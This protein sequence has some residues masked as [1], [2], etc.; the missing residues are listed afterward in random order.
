MSEP[1]VTNLLCPF[2]PAQHP[3]IEEVEKDSVARWGARMGLKP[4]DRDFVKMTRARFAS[5]AG[6]AHPGATLERLDP[7]VDFIIF[8][9]LWDDQFDCRIG[10]E[11]VHPAALYIQ[12]ALATQVLEGTT[13]NEDSSPLL[14]ALSDMRGWLDKH[15]PGI[16]MER[17]KKSFVEYFDSTGWEL[18][19][20]HECAVP[21]LAKYVEMRRMTSGGYWVTHLIEVAE[22]I[23]LSDEAW[24]H[25]AMQELVNATANIIG[26]ANDLLSLRNELNDSGH[27]NMVFSIQKEYGLPLQD[28]INAAVGMHNAEMRRFLKL[29]AQLPSFGDEDATVNRFV[30]GLCRWMRAN[31]DWS[32]LTGRYQVDANEVLAD[33]MPEAAPEWSQ[34]EFSVLAALAC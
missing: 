3:R 25:P 21:T 10:G 11:L 20:R 15:M 26:W 31:I 4:Q 9:F 19:Q 14:W 16:W 12:N 28:A 17:F 34:A 24:N 22:G 33:E 23:C 8:L 18:Q 1:K 5:M 32:I 2:L 7:V 13:P 27:L 30:W 29:K 6:H